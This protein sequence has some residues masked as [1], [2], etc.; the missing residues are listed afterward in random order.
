M[1]LLL[2]YHNQPGTFPETGLCHTLVDSAQPALRMACQ[3]LS[4]EHGAGTPLVGRGD[5]V[6]VCVCVGVGGV[7]AQTLK[8]WPPEPENLDSNSYDTE[9]PCPEACPLNV[10]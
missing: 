7:M 10:C 4:H 9:L 1:C 5:G 2:T 8:A 3:V 6:C